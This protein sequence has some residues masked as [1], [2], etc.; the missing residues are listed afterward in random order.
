MG[1]V[2][3]VVTST[4]ATIVVMLPTCAVRVTEDMP[5]GDGQLND[6][7]RLL[8]ERRVIVIVIGGGG[9]AAAGPSDAEA[10]VV[11]PGVRIQFRSIRFLFSPVAA[12]R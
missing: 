3:L 8:P 11:R 5:G 7:A 9:R 10:L 12:T 6:A 1:S 2:E 4:A